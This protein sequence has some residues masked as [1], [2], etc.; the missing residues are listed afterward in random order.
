VTGWLALRREAALGSWQTHGWP[1][2]RLEA[3]RHTN[4]RTVRSL[5]GAAES[6][7]NGGTASEAARWNLRDATSQDGVTVAPLTPAAE[8]DDPV[9]KQWLGNVANT[10]GAADAVAARN[11][12]GF[13]GGVLIHAASGVVASDVIE[14]D[15]PADAT[16]SEH[17][18]RVLI[19]A[20]RNA[21][22]TVIHR[23]A[24]D[25]RYVRNVVAEVVVG[26]GAR[27]RH[28][29]LQNDGKEA[30]HLAEIAVHQG[31]DSRFEGH[32]IQ[33]GGALGRVGCTV[34]FD[35]KGASCQ[36]D[37]LYIGDGRQHLDSNLVVHHDQGHTSSE[38]L[39][40]GVLD[41]GSEGVFRG[42]VLIK[43]GASKSVSEQLNRNLL[44]S[45]TASANTK[46][47]L[48]I[49]ND[50]V[51]AAHGSTVGE[52]DDA[53]LFY[54]RSRGISREDA[55]QLLTWGFVSE[56]VHRLPTKQLRAEVTELTGLAP[57]R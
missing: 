13:A 45:D 11:L 30:F 39:Y 22:L 16:A 18:Q 23:F 34:H 1:S 47:Q 10:D 3:W 12:A 21:E 29:W 5:A 25:G 20:E 46:P 40:K 7:T 49:D 17:V 31:R 24:G 27:V 28:V 42:N 50:D 37:G 26:D 36:L 14:L 19:V 52:L 33:V 54:L 32:V 9:A 48:E 44:L 55:Q 4:L 35:Q 43:D 41:G 51:R 6:T 2:Q 56:V 15:F 53:A 57:D 38:M 8:A